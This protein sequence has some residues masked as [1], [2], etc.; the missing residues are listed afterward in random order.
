MFY[1]SRFSCFSIKLETTTHLCVCHSP[2]QVVCGLNHTLCLGRDNK[3]YACGW[4]TDG[5]TGTLSCSFYTL[6]NASPIPAPIPPLKCTPVHIPH[7]GVGHYES[8]SQL[9]QVSLNDEDVSSIHTC[10][11]T[12]FV[13]TGQTYPHSTFFLGS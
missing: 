5:Q 6:S 3:V 7:A 9:T 11:D 4:S 13:L 12:S 10:A 1:P 8:V 2:F